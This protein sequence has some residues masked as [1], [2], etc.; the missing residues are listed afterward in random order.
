MCII[1]FS[2]GERF[3]SYLLCESKKLALS[4]ADVSATLVPL[5]KLHVLNIIF[6]R[7]W[8][9]STMMKVFQSNIAAFIA[10]II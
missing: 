6:V 9:Y 1:R 8:V 10:R 4:D 2:K 3:C 5:G 7:I